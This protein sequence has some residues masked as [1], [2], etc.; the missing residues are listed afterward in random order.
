MLKVYED[1][2]KS[3]KEKMEKAEIFANKI[4]LFKGKIIK[5][6]LTGEEQY[7]EFGNRYKNMYLAW[8]INRSHYKSK[9]NCSITNYN[10]EYDKYLF[11]VYINPLSLF[12]DDIYETF[13]LEKIQNECKVFFYDN[14]NSKYYIEDEYIE[15]FLEKLNEWYINAKNKLD[16][17][18][19]EQKIKELEEQLDELKGKSE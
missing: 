18:R 6:K 12:G 17:Y 5:E 2:L 13:G 10:G 7:I 19:R 9:S 8:G 16:D 1:E 14:F 3:L 4:P 11:T 15:E